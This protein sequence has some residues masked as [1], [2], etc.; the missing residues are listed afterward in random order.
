METPEQIDQ[1]AQVCHEALRAFSQTLGDNS[2]LPW[3]QAPEWQRES[4][5]E[6]VR[7]QFAQFAKGI[8]PSPSAT[9]DDWLRQKRADGWKHGSAKNEKSKEH[10]SLVAYA[11]LP[12]TEKQKDY[13]FVAICRAFCQ[14]VADEAAKA[15]ARR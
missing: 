2:L 1:A 6:G 11:D 5:R 3:D 8:E 4:S 12:L 9:H 15:T 13:L 14:S 7:F 10:P